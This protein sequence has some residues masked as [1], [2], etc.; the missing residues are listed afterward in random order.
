MVSSWARGASSASRIARTKAST[1]AAG[2]SQPVR[3]GTTSSGMPEIALQ[4]A[5][6]PSASASITTTGS[7]SEQLGVQPAANHMDLRPVA[8][9]QP[10]V[11]LGS[12]E[13]ADRDEERG[14]GGLLP[15]GIE[16]L[17]PV[18]GEA[19]GGPAELTTEQRYRRRVVAKVRVEV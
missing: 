18:D 9:V 8:L 17:L 5:G 10:A 16:V 2:T 4:M 6:R 7:P 13:A 12:P 1:D 19:E 11:V 14:V 15:E 3:P